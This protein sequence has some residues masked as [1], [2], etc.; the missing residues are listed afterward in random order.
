[1]FLLHSSLKAASVSYDPN[2]IPHWEMGRQGFK[3]QRPGTFAARA[4]AAEAEARLFFW[5]AGST[6]AES[7]PGKA[8]VSFGP[9]SWWGRWKQK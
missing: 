5:H 6:L 7:E 8:A 4:L 1:M 9:V 3:R 2:T